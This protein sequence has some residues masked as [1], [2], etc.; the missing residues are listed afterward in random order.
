MKK[1]AAFEFRTYGES[2]FF[3]IKTLRL[4]YTKFLSKE[5]YRN[6]NDSANIKIIVKLDYI[7]NN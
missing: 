1:N 6:A 2:T 3:G 5:K 4:N 7:L